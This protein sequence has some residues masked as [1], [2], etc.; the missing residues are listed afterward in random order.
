MIVCGHLYIKHKEQGW[1]IHIPSKI[2]GSIGIFPEQNLFGYIE[3]EPGRL[4]LSPLRLTS[5]TNYYRMYLDD[6]RGSLAKIT[7]VF[8]NRR[9][10]ILSGGAFGFSNIWV[11]EFLIDFADSRTSPDEIMDEIGDMGGFVTSRE[12]TEL[13]PLGFNLQEN[14]KVE[15]EGEN[16]FVV[17][18]NSAKA[19]LSRSVLGVVKAWPKIRAIFI[20][21]FNPETNIVHIRAGIK[22]Q[23]G[24]ITALAE[25]LGTQVNLNAIDEMHHSIASGEW[26]AYGEL[27][28]GTLEELKSKVN[29]LETVNSFVVEP[30]R[31]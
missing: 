23:P 13:F 5:T 22:D 12:I 21:F 11:A 14:Y 28:L 15:G 10:N 30:L 16:I 7:R 6:V 18:E 8:S 17:S 26:N 19:S 25:V 29:R 9:L 27:V 3:H 4:L 31:I 2:A 24:S 1:E 20:D